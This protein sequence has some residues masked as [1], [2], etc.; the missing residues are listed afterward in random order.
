MEHHRVEVG[1]KEQKNDPIGASV[2]ADIEDDLEIKG[3]E[4][5]SF[6][7]FFELNAE[8]QEEKAK[9]IAEKLLVDPI[10]QEYSLNKELS[11]AFDWEIE[12]KLKKEVTDNVGA[13]ARQAIEDLLDRKLLEEETIRSGR[14]YLLR[15]NIQ[16]EE[17]KRIC[18][19]LLANELIEEFSY[20]K[21]KK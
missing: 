7:E 21:G 18:T 1:F 15:G 20:R 14:K 3:I 11:A 8:L 16:E 2:K 6:I 10:I 9:E 17:V 5:V 19:G 12:V 4:T 13:T